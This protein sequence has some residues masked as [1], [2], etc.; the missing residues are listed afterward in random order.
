[1][2]CGR[3]ARP[4]RTGAIWT[5]IAPDRPEPCRELRLMLPLVGSVAQAA[6][7]ELSASAPIA[8][9]HLRPVIFGPRWP[10]GPGVRPAGRSPAA[11]A[12]YQPRAFPGQPD[13]A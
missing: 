3:H 2:S 7:A 9:S 13:R 1:M 5:P 10:H 4:G 11:D 12:R 6:V 8:A